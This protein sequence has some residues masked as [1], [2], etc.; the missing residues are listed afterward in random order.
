MDNSMCHNG[1]KV[2]NEFDNLKLDRVTRPPYSPDL[3]PCDFWRCEMLKRKIKDRV[4]QVVERIIT[5]VY[6]VWDELTLEELESI[7]F[8]WIERFEW[9][10]EHEE[11][12]HTT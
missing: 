2:T 10:I 12:Y 4:F 8:N 1:R 9:P 11:K 7:L 6:M 3:S 5:A